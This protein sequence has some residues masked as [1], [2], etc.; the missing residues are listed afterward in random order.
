MTIYMQN[1]GRILDFCHVFRNVPHFQIYIFNN[2]RVM[3]R[4][5]PLEHV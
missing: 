5:N 4:L 3:G 1:I 2:Y